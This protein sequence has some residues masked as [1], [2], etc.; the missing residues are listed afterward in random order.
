[1]ITYQEAV[2]FIHQIPP[3]SSKPGLE[4]IRR[5]LNRLGNPQ[6][7]LRFLHIAGTNG[8]GSAAA[9]CASVL[10]EAGYRVGLYISPFVLDFRERFQI[11][12]E[13]IREEE[14]LE[15]FCPVKAEYDWMMA[16]GYECNEYDFITA[17]AFLYFQRNHCDIVCL[18]VGLGGRAD[19]T[20]IIPTPEAELI[21]RIDYDHMGILGDTLE[22]IAREKAGIIK[23]GSVCISYPQQED[24]AL[25]VLMERCAKTGSSL[26]LPA[27]DSVELLQC[28]EDGT[29]FRYDGQE[30]ALRLLGKHQALNAA[31]VIEAIRSLKQFPVTQQQ[32]K[33]G[34]YKTCFPARMEVMGR[35]PLILLDGA[36]NANGV[37]AMAET[38]RSLK[39]SPK[40]ALMGVV[41][42]KDYRRELN[43]LSG[44]VDHLVATEITSTPRGLSSFL[45]A[46]A[47]E[48]NGYAVTD[49]PDNRAALE[50]AR[51][52]AGE[53][54]GIFV[55]GSLF[56][57]SD[58]RK[59]FFS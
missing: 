7:D 46:K 21:M 22:E 39:C 5:L 25:A 18:E 4:R 28:D 33:D 30:Y 24:E 32:L 59:F 56:L 13:M 38:I 37:R 17:L 40:I 19:A 27:A 6:N 42:D 44:V 14:L 41:R 45:L 48:G 8:K 47:A 49:C 34:L 35:K 36:H 9:M 10:R 20:N 55:F 53:Q 29:R 12:G 31:T 43:L 23:P 57:A 26:V 58:M 52:L 11:D 3:F 15:L 1:M 54:G 50:Y 16:Q 2:E 51:K